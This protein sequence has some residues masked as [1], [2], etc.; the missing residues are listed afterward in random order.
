MLKNEPPHRIMECASGVSSAEA[1]WQGCCR[2]SWFHLSGDSTDLH[3][4][5]FDAPLI[6][7][8]YSLRTKLSKSY[9]EVD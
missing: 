8:Y 6:K 3:V 1:A 7:V 9:F 4:W 2:L 5:K